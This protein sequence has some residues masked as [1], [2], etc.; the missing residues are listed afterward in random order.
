MFHLF[1]R[2]TVVMKHT[3]DTNNTQTGAGETLFKT[4]Q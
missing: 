4:E 2:L 1:S 3:E